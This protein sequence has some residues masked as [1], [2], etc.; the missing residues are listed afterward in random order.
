MSLK[1]ILYLSIFATN[2]LNFFCI[3]DSAV[4]EI[5]YAVHLHIFLFHISEFEDIAKSFCVKV[6][7]I[8]LSIFVLELRSLSS[9]R[10]YNLADFIRKDAI[11]FQRCTIGHEYICLKWSGFSLKI[12]II[13]YL[14]TNDELR[15]HHLLLVFKCLD[16]NP[17]Y[18]YKNKRGEEELY[19]STSNILFC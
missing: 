6:L 10:V 14:I 11:I 15:I 8:L 3:K 13:I 12:T 4:Y 1:S 18:S 19:W 2:F 16:I 17:F 7:R 5:L 9:G